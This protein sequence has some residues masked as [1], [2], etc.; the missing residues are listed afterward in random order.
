M[1]F[2]RD[3]FGAILKWLIVVLLGCSAA[4]FVISDEATAE[5]ASLEADAAAEQA[6]EETEAARAMS[7]A[8]VVVASSDIPAFTFEF[9]TE[10][11]AKVSLS[12]QE[13]Q[14]DLCFFL[15]SG[16]S[17]SSVRASFQEPTDGSFCILSSI[18]ASWT[19]LVSGEPFDLSS[20]LA[21]DGSLGYSLT[22]GIVVDGQAMTEVNACLMQSS[23]AASVFLMST[24]PENE[25]RPFIDGSPDHST[26]ASGSIRVL[27]DDAS[28]RYAGEFSVLKGRG[29]TS[30][31][32]ASKKSYQV[33]LN[34]KADL[35]DIAVPE[36]ESEEAKKWLLIGNP[37]DP[38]LMRNEMMYQ[39]AKDIGMPSAIDAEA[40]DL[41]YDGE[42]R[43]AYLLTEKVE[44]GSGRVDIDDLKSDIEDANLDV[45]LESLPTEQGV[46]SYGGQAQYVPAVQ[47]PDD[48]TGGYLIE[49]DDAFYAAER[50]WFTTSTGHHFVSKSP[51]HLSYRQMDYVSALVNEA[52]ECWMNGGVHPATGKQL[53]D[54][55][56]QES[57]VKYFFLQEFS[58]NADEFV[59]STY[60]YIPRGESKLYAG[61]LWDCDGTFGIRTELPS[62][63]DTSSWMMRSGT[64]ALGDYNPFWNALASVYDDDI[65][66]AAM[67]MV[68]G[69]ADSPGSIAYYSG[70]NEASRSMNAKIWGLAES[71]S[72]VTQYPDYETSLSALQSWAQRRLSWMEGDIAKKGAVSFMYRVYNPNSGE[73]FYTAS[74]FERDSLVVAGWDDEGIGW[75]APGVSNVPVYRL[76][77]GTDH[78]YTTSAGERDALVEVGW[79]YEGIGWYSDDAKRMPLYRQFNPNVQPN[80]PTNN[81]GSHHY[82]TSLHESDA[83]ASIG[84]QKEGIGWYG[85]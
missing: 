64:D 51:E 17:L 14:G 13:V 68:Y 10:D 11:A 6:C 31:T 50:S 72:L 5:D 41:Y 35:L 65:K 36:G 16:V 59:S 15:P 23:N 2:V 62:F 76:Y 49:M 70:K 44:V 34:K 80:A 18:D 48:I 29:N 82:T 81:S 73:H 40:V 60:F 20:Y 24:D 26:K 63:R 7:L 42:Y 56:D 54:Y 39:L 78:H 28:E 8:E 53:F 83:L 71:I 58:K 61:P 9:E 79:S 19:V 37:F 4:L 3:R 33:K 32:A 47:D 57:L 25:G 74:A 84:W 38:T 21:A 67:N 85:M 43:G 52:F 45:D 69:T 1:V 27:S 22:L 30:W 12:P 46:T 75:T 77:S 55:F 66:D